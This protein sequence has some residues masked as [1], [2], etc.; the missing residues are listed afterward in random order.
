MQVSWCN[1]T[2]LHKKLNNAQ[3]LS[4]PLFQQQLVDYDTVDQ[5]LTIFSLPLVIEPTR[6]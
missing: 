4:L 3:I 6:Q 5:R 1:K 2:K